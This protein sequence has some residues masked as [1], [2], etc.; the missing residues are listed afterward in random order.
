MVFTNERGVEF[1]GRAKHAH[2]KQTR[3]TLQGHISGTIESVRIVGR[4]EL[5]QSERARDEFVLLVLREERNPRESS[6]IEY[7][8]FSPPAIISK[9]QG[10]SAMV[11]LVD[12][13]IR[14]LNDSQRGVVGSMLHEDIPLIIAHGK[15][16]LFMY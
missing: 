7:L 8:W 16:S 9:D 6:F 13:Y 2:G 1:V 5:T 4:E 14:G 11:P 15:S 3:I 10:I 12:P